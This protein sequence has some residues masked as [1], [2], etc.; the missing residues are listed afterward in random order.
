MEMLKRAVGW[1]LAGVVLVAV[2]GCRQYTSFTVRVEDAETGKPLRGAQVKA[3]HS[4]PNIESYFFGLFPPAESRDITDLDGLARVRMT[5]NAE[6][7]IHGVNAIAPGYLQGAAQVSEEQ[8]RAWTKR[9]AKPSK[10]PDV[11]VRLYAEPEPRLVLVIPKKYRG[12]IRLHEVYSEKLFPAGKRVFDVEVR[13][14]GVHSVE[15]PVFHHRLRREIC[16]ADGSPVRVGREPPAGAVGVGWIGQLDSRTIYAVGTR[17]EIQ[18]VVELAQP[19]GRYSQAAL[20]RLW[21]GN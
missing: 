18:R 20:E 3:S 16:W 1:L 5:A 21:R 14:P 8:L 11:T 9:E 19:G 6:G 10:G 15:V 2:T 4:I 12:L 17:E 13:G 7:S